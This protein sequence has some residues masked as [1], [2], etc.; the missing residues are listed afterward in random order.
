MFRC[1]SRLFLATTREITV[2]LSMMGL[3]MAEASDAK[4]LKEKYLDLVRRN[5]PDA[6]GDER[7]MKEV[8][9]S[10]QVLSRITHAERLRH[11]EE[12]RPQKPLKSEPPPSP[13]IR[14]DWVGGDVGYKP[15]GR[16]VKGYAQGNSNRY[17][18]WYRWCAR[19]VVTIFIWCLLWSLLFSGGSIEGYIQ[20][21]RGE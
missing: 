1:C 21:L 17:N 2:A 14:E 12:T 20:L 13:L 15:W 18:R 11:T 6:G 4:G 10:F 7:R 3:T 19:S 9:R 8:V 5:H 16:D